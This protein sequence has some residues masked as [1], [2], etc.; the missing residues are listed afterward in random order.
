VE[1][2]DR[3]P[4]GIDLDRPSAARTYDV[5]LGGSH[6]FA[7][8]RRLARAAVAAM[9]DVAEQA[10]ANRA[11]LH[12]TVRY[13]L[14]AGV[15]QFL[16]LGSGIPTE[17][18]VHEV[19]RA[20]CPVA[21]VVYADLDPI[22]VRHTRRLLLG[23]PHAVAVRHDLRD[24]AGVLG[25][26]EVTAL[27]DFDRP[28]AVLILGVLHAIPDADDPGGIVARL[29]DRLSPGGYLAIAHA[30]GDSRPAD[31]GALARLSRE[32]PTAMTLR[33]RDEIAGLFA[34]VD[35]VEP[36]LTWVSAWRPEPGEE[37]GRPERCANLGAV[38]VKR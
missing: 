23:V 1:R 18:A 34:G 13:L 35:L 25:R 5:L 24:T 37:P 8:D 16:D 22:A 3:L 33:R 17:G 29:R 11:F 36:G 28:L 32:T 26:P 14:A 7:V 31:T 9:P 21:R 12:R 15:C 4:E 20:A 30:T 6:N 19:A 10:Q 38:G 27:F 2:P